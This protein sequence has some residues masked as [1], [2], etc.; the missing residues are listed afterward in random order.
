MIEN[1]TAYQD[2][3]S[4]R[5]YGYPWVPEGSFSMI[6]PCFRITAVDDT[7]VEH[8]GIPDSSSHS[9]ALRRHSLLLVLAPRAHA[10]KTA[11]RDSQHPLGSSLGAHRHPRPLTRPASSGEPKGPARP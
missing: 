4:V 5:L 9:P 2:L 11:P 8:D 10:G 6:V 3:V 1:I 7:G